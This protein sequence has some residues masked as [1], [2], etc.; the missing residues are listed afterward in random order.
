MASDALASGTGIQRNSTYD[1]IQFIQAKEKEE[2]EKL[3]GLSGN[4]SGG[5]FGDHGTSG[6]C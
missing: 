5:L 3:L 6:I 4:R 1:L 2:R